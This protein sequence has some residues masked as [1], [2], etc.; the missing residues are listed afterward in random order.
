MTSPSNV[1]TPLHPKIHTPETPQFGFHDN[2]QPYSPRSSR[3]SS[4]RYQLHTETTDKK[5]TPA[6]STR[7]IRSSHRESKS[8]Q[9]SSI[10][11]DST[12]SCEANRKKPKFDE[13]HADLQTKKTP[14]DSSSK[15]LDK[16]DHDYSFSPLNTKS[17]R[18]SPA[19]CYR[20]MG[21]LMTPTKTPMKRSRKNLASVSSVARKIFSNELTSH[22]SSGLPS[23]EKYSEITSRES[24]ATPDAEEEAER[25]SIFTDPRD[26]IPEI[27]V[28]PNNPFFLDKNSIH[29]NTS[30][31]LSKPIKIA[32]KGEGFQTSDELVRREDGLLYNFRGKVIFRKF[33][34]NDE[35]NEYT[36]DNLAED[37]VIPL[38]R[39]IHQSTSRTVFKPRLLFPPIPKSTDPQTEKIIT[40]GLGAGS[41]VEDSP[42]L[43]ESSTN[44]AEEKSSISLTPKSQPASSPNTLR[45]CPI[46]L[47]TH[48]PNDR[49]IRPLRNAKQELG[50]S[51]PLAL[52]NTKKVRPFASWQCT[53]PLSEKT[54][55]RGGE[56]LCRDSPDK[57]IKL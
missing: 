16:N 7:S 34:N 3:I 37:N 57:K 1:T 33:D 12:Q 50:E 56:P 42:L 51:K 19:S 36:K 24:S 40:K 6:P 20:G 49:P 44:K 5:T 43:I 39:S 32:V 17:N 26:R 25:I 31:S 15:S 41:A 14:N 2:Y 45:T 8:L 53:K 4:R 54:R 55:K 10:R 38:P 21:M 27:D 22:E 11:N 47:K 29:R 35:S 13:L 48:G 23:T 30:K 28:S 52:R 46:T 9:C 18:S